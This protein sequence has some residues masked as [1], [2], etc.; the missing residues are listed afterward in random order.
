MLHFPLE[1]DFPTLEWSGFVREYYYYLLIPSVTY[2]IA[3]KLGQN[4]MRD[5]EP[6]EVSRL[7]IFWNLFLTIFSAIGTHRMWYEVITAS[8]DSR[9]FISGICLPGV[10][11]SR[12]GFWF[13]LFAFSKFVEFGDT[14]FL[15]VKKK[16]VIFL[17]WYH[18][19]TVMLLT[20]HIWANQHPTG[21]YFTLMN[22]S[23]HSVMYGYYSLTAM[24]IKI[25]PKVAFCI[26]SIQLSQMFIGL[27][28]SVLS[29]IHCNQHSNSSA[30]FALTIYFSYA[31]LFAQFMLDSYFR[32]RSQSLIKSRIDNNNKIKGA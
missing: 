31:L 20:F 16:P 21:R 30:Y 7:L 8:T 18:H 14:F 17:H 1:V 24:K 9:S 3:I 27:F 15:V 10:R 25:H 4:Y 12:A 6:M 26:T 23:V 2:L 5:R 22:F 13:M 19:I 29:L 28:I 11:T 32:K